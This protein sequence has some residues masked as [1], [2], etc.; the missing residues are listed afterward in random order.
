MAAQLTEYEEV[1]RGGT[2]VVYRGVLEGE[3]GTSRPVAVKRLQPERRDDPT[4]LDLF[5]REA[6]LG[7]QLAHPNVVHAL[8]LRKDENGYALLTEWVDGV[9]LEGLDAPLAWTQV[10]AI[11]TSLCEALDYLHRLEGTIVHRDVTPS[12]VFLTRQGMV[13]LGDLGVACR[14]D[15]PD[16]PRVATRG[17]AAPEQIAGAALDARSDLFAL[18][19][20]LQTL[21][22][23]VESPVLPILERATENNPDERFATAQ[24]M[25]RALESALN[26]HGE[27][28]DA[29]ALA[30]LVPDRSERPALDSA[31]RSILGGA[32]DSPVHEPVHEPDH[33]P[34][35]GPRT[36]SE[37]S[38]PPKRHRWLALTPWLGAAVIASVGVYLATPRPAPPARERIAPIDAAAKPEDSDLEPVQEPE[39]TPK[40]K[41]TRPVRSKDAPSTR[42]SAPNHVPITVAA[43][44]SLKVGS[45]PWAEVQIDGK[46]VGN[47]PIRITKLTA[48][49]HALQVRHPPT[50]QS[51]TVQIELKPERET[52]VIVDLNRDEVRVR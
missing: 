41:P 22:G 49:P 18:G 38:G 37:T 9:T 29:R 7:T 5:V 25:K 3:H 23:G 10:A 39:S 32:L 2:C 30:E 6:K 35:A 31:V 27:R 42:P 14:P 15:D 36:T 11:G 26:E 50:G 4:A 48:G 43:T 13:K 52:T 44:A 45:T 33:E 8:E 17:F 21:T 47:T 24:E 34:A 1:G 51:K 28:A 19:R 46:R 40:P 20:T 16:A 12:N